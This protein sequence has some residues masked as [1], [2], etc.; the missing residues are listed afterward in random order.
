M[1]SKKFKNI[2]DSKQAAPTIFKSIYCIIYFFRALL[3]DSD[4]LVYK[5]KGSLQLTLRRRNMTKQ[6]LQDA[7]PSLLIAILLFVICNLPGY[8]YAG[9]PFVETALIEKDEN[10]VPYIEYLIDPNGAL[11]LEEIFS[12]EH[13][14]S[15]LPL[16]EGIP[17]QTSGVTWLRFT[18]AP[19]KAPSEAPVI[20]ELGE[21]IPAG[22]LVYTPKNN[23]PTTNGPSIWHL[24]RA[25]SDG[26]FKIPAPNANGPA[27]V[28]AR[29]PGTPDLWFAPRLYTNKYAEDAKSN[30]AHF[31][32][33]CVL[34][35]SIT[36]C[37]LRAFRD[38]GEWR[39][40][41]AVLAGLILAQPLLRIPALP[42]GFS[43]YTT[44][45]LYLLVPALGLILIPHI[46]RHLWNTPA[47][48][49]KLDR[50]LTFFSIVG[51][52]LPLATLVPGLSWTGKLLP[53]WPVSAIFGCIAA[54]FAVK[55]KLPGSGRYLLS[56]LLL[57]AAG[58]STL[59]AQ[60]TTGPNSIFLDA[61]LWGGSAA[62]LLLGILPLRN[63]AYRGEEVEQFS[64]DSDDPVFLLSDVLDAGRMPLGNTL[65]QSDCAATDASLLINTSTAQTEKA[66][67]SPLADSAVPANNVKNMITGQPHESA[68]IQDLP[69]QPAGLKHIS[70]QTDLSFS[71]LTLICN[72]GE[73]RPMP[74]PV[75]REKENAPEQ[76]KDAVAGLN[77]LPPQSDK[78]LP[79]ATLDNPP[80]T[81]PHS[82]E[83]SASL[84]ETDSSGNGRYVHVGS[85]PGTAA[86]KEQIDKPV[87]THA[88][89][90]TE[91]EQAP[92]PT[93]KDMVAQSAFSSDRVG[94]TSEEIPDAATEAH[95]AASF[96][97]PTNEM[98][99]ARLEPETA[100][101]TQHQ[102][103][104]S[105]FPS[106][107]NSAK[108]PE[109]QME[110]PV[111]STSLDSKP[112]SNEPA[113]DSSTD[114]P[115]D[116]PEPN[117]S[118]PPRTLV[119]P[120]A[121]E[122]EKTALLPEASDMQGNGPSQ[123]EEI[124]NIKPTSQVPAPKYEQTVD[125]TTAHGASLAP[126]DSAGPQPEKNEQPDTL[127]AKDLVEL[128]Q[129][130]PEAEAEEGIPDKK[131]LWPNAAEKRVLLDE[132][133][134]LKIATPQNEAASDNQEPTA[135]AIKSETEASAIQMPVEPTRKNTPG[136]AATASDTISEKAD[137]EAI[138]L[139]EKRLLP[140]I[141]APAQ[142]VRNSA[143]KTEQPTKISWFNRIRQSA[144]KKP[145]QSEQVQPSSDS[146]YF[147]EQKASGDVPQFDIAALNK[148][149]EA[150]KIP[151]ESLMQA[152]N[153]LS[154]C[155]LPPLAKV[156]S[157][158]IM[159]NT[160]AIADIINTLSCGQDEA[161]RKL[162]ENDTQSA[163]T[164]FDLQVVLREAHD[165]VVTKAERCGLALSWF[166]PPHLP[167]LY[168]GNPAQLQEVLHLLLDSAIEST[169][170]GS[171]Q[172]TARRLPDSTDPGH[173]VFSV[174]DSGQTKPRLRRSTTALMKAW[175]MVTAQG[176][177]LSLD[178][179]PN[180]STVIS[181]TLRLEVPGK[182]VQHLLPL[183]TKNTT[184]TLP[185]SNSNGE[186]QMRPLTIL[187]AAEQPTNRQL[188]SF[189]LNDLPYIVEEARNVE[190]AF[191]HYLRNPAGV[192]IID[193]SLAELNLKEAI[194]R[195]H[196]IDAA[197]NIP[198]VPVI[199]LVND[200]TEGAQV[201][202][203][204]SRLALSEPL[205]RSEV[206]DAIEMLLPIPEAV[207]ESLKPTAAPIIP[208]AAPKSQASVTA[209]PRSEACPAEPLEV[210]A[211]LQKLPEE[212]ILPQNQKQG[213]EPI[214]V[215]KSFASA[216]KRFIRVRKKTPP[217]PTL[218]TEQNQL[219]NEKEGN[220]V[221]EARPITR[222]PI[223]TQREQKIA[224]DQAEYV[225]SPPQV[226]ADKALDNPNEQSSSFGQTSSVREP[227][228]EGKEP[229][230]S[231]DCEMQIE[232]VNQN[233]DTAVK[234][235]APNTLVAELSGAPIHI[236]TP[237][238]QAT[239]ATLQETLQL[240][241]SPEVNA[242]EDVNDDLHSPRPPAGEEQDVATKPV[243]NLTDQNTVAL[244]TSIEGEEIDP[245]V[246]HLIPGLLDSLEH[247]L[248]D[249]HASLENKSFLGIS[250]ACMRIAGTADAHG[251]RVIKGIAN[252]VERAASANDL[253]AVSDLLAELAN[254]VNTNRIKLEAIYLE[255]TGHSV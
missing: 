45:I 29:I 11:S 165:A 215:S 62:A 117:S 59:L 158:A 99:E 85:I 107:L 145:E 182:Q 176:G 156:Q 33:I 47:T 135:E 250:E 245:E 113:D 60:T 236:G 238:V 228:T 31:L 247:A 81:A 249:A 206:R 61:P 133:L 194:N 112:D 216:A 128:L 104:K 58:L 131:T 40:W 37:L 7:S 231:S 198:P 52:L 164:V 39:L 188:F 57:S 225:Y 154:N 173:L 219:N 73:P 192:V 138:S 246:I 89:L 65:P 6:K 50:F 178:S 32:A 230:K 147:S 234:E 54:I 21:H 242:S 143:E 223:V 87:K 193:G 167:L 30:I 36:L 70:N 26:L 251:L 4:M 56:M 125:T 16:S 110:Q 240:Q 155:S 71:G 161:L 51:G 15:F 171:I 111:R 25:A 141:A 241:E 207:L 98:E 103:N 213:D 196:E 100:Q 94:L 109:I 187:V 211:D 72:V 149:E 9:A 116:L 189:F 24:R 151:L 44:A 10:L 150:L 67:V 208:P 101:P 108:A 82:Q 76:G 160:K 5:L 53:L 199:T 132:P 244:S 139:I 233:S 88:S 239:A 97:L 126:G 8:S 184:Q 27:S 105:A 1:S 248:E 253:D 121:P 163:D 95:Q 217:L 190:E 195:L 91:P 19:T 205:S 75:T 232:S 159:K 28:Y 220:G 114:T 69:G 120:K 127:S 66:S 134:V 18:L 153:E 14:K 180:R 136:S 177:T 140:E 79:E 92:S 48:D 174:T 130:A 77:E 243:Q 179:T 146:M 123:R 212:E 227:T 168:K 3:N 115:I 64:N 175:E 96:E 17:L 80:T 181:F 13:H 214:S 254:S 68:V 169:A 226:A 204:G 200:K 152:T 93:E 83:L 224:H 12:A 119:S 201:I 122:F 78:D 157:V 42:L 74:M 34:G 185:G 144:L 38:G 148:V 237:D 86:V 43:Y 166:M 84:V 209:E 218:N 2:T 20:L 210:V 41:T 49:K 55:S 186:G 170:R 202:Q 90:T 22:A 63:N 118:Q 183:L 46:A 229:E 129:T 35:L 221:S 162:A 124:A 137:K 235:E 197:Q 252:C 222:Y 203:A 142:P 255:H 191:E 106:L 172:V 102:P 23:E